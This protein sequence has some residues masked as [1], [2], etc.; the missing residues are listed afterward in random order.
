MSRYPPVGGPYGVDGQFFIC[1]TCGKSVPISQIEGQCV[2]GNKVCK[3]CG[4]QYP[5]CAHCGWV[6]C[7]NCAYQ[8]R[9]G[10]WYHI[11]HKPQECLIVTACFGS[12]QAAEV[13][14]LRAFRDET[15]LK[16]SFGNRLMHVLERIYYSFSPQVATYL[17]AHPSTRNVVKKNIVVPFLQSLSASKQLTRSLSNMEFKIILI[18]WLSSM[19]ITIGMPFWQIISF[20]RGRGNS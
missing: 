18:A 4:K 11:Q 16:A 17:D 10:K 6:I 3:A 15:V 20:F 13:Q 19:N 7:R 14:Y 12:P 1:A 5:L 8:S 2:C 9:S